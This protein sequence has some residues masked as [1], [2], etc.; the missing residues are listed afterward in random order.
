M[1]HSPR[2]D[3]SLDAESLLESSWDKDFLPVDPVSICNLIGVGAYM[4]P[5]K[6][7]TDSIV[8]R[9]DQGENIYVGTHVSKNRRRYLFARGLGGV[10]AK[11]SQVRVP[12]RT[13]ALKAIRM[14]SPETS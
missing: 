3:A 1:T 11:G 14:F 5:L 12:Q 8:V 7:G 9:D 2:T 10:F 13:R 4:A 6:E